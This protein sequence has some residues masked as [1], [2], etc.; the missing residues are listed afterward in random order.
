MINI[1]YLSL[2]SFI[3]FL[4]LDYFIK[5]NYLGNS[6]K[7]VYFKFICLGYLSIVFILTSISFLILILFSYFDIFLICFDN[8]LFDNELFNLMSDSGGV[9]T[10]SGSTN[11]NINTEATVNINHPNLSVSIPSSSLNNLAAASVAGGEGLALK[12]IQ[13]IPGGPGVK[14]VA[15][16]GTMLTTQALTIGVGKILNSNNSSNNNK[17]Q[18][19]INSFDNLKSSFVDEISNNNLNNISNLSE[20]YNDL[21]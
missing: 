18:K 5:N 21:F 11:N 4:I 14:V 19:F 15:G 12:V 8:S 10:N 2:L 17:I 6:I 7:K 3:S 16:A 1:K 20:K 13:Q 9:N